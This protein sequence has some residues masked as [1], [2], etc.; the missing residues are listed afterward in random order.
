MSLNGIPTH[1]PSILSAKTVPALDGATTVI[2][3]MLRPTIH[4]HHTACHKKA[5]FVKKSFVVVFS[6]VWLAL[7][8]SLPTSSTKIWYVFYNTHAMHVVPKIFVSWK[9]SNICKQKYFNINTEIFILNALNEAEIKWG[10][11]ELPSPWK[12]IPSCEIRFTWKQILF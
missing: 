11:G 8:R 4:Y 9:S 12:G 6:H 10:E 5:I 2:S 1:D 3:P 7:L